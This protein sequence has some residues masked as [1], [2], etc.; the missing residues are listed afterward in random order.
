MELR[1]LEALAFWMQPTGAALLA[2][3][4]CSLAWV[5]SAAQDGHRVCGLLYRA[6]VRGAWREHED[7]R[8]QAF[9]VRRHTMLLWLMMPPM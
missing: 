1:G 5:W 9:L 7:R 2:V 3:K 8:G 4:R 6:A